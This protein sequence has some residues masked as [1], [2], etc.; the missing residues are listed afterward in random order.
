MEQTHKTAHHEAGHFIAYLLYIAKEY[1]Y[2]GLELESL[3]II[4]DGDSFGRLVNHPDAKYYNIL[5]VLMAGAA[6]DFILSG[7]NNSF[8]FLDTLLAEQMELEGSDSDGI[9]ELSIFHVTENSNI[10]EFL[11]SDF[12]DV[13]DNIKKNW[14]AVQFVANEL[15]SKK[16]IEGDDLHNLV[17]VTAEKLGVEIFDL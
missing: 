7:E 14:E 8:Q 6:S 10:T 15:I 12:T 4:P 3:S 13:V 1:G 16:L 5:P 11:H 17:I 9:V 2:E